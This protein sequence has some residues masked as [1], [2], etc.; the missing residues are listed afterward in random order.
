M[1]LHGPTTINT[2]GTMHPS[3]HAIAPLARFRRGFTMI[4]ILIV[5]FL[6]TL[7]LAISTVMFSRLLPSSRLSTTARE[8]S[9]TIKYARTLAQRTGEKQTVVIDLDAHRYGIEGRGDKEVPFGV[10]IKVND[11]L[12]GE[13][14]RGTYPIVLY[15]NGGMEGGIIE[16]SGGQKRL[17]VEIDPVVGSLVVK[18]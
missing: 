2:T 10:T 17:L 5:I 6:I 11:P 1:P 12:S 7:I 13:V 18:P 4:E 15:A 8:I 16:V 3:L 9:T 14:S